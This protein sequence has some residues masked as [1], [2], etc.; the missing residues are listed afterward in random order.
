MARSGVCLPREH[1]PW[2]GRG[3]PHCCSRGDDSP[4][5]SSPNVM[6]RW[7]EPGKCFLHSTFFCPLI[8]LQAFSFTFWAPFYLASSSRAAFVQLTKE[9]RASDGKRGLSAA[10]S[11]DACSV[12]SPT[13]GA[14]GSMWQASSHRRRLPPH[15]SSSS[16]SQ[17]QPGG[18][19]WQAA[20]VL[21]RGWGELE[22]KKKKKTA[23][24][25]MT[26]VVREGR[27]FFFFVDTLTSLDFNSSYTG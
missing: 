2:R 26:L 21:I 25:T 16:M 20:G 19:T 14:V 12:S 4:A 18:P 8:S 15:G 17:G 5:A 1:G 7:E 3:A 11:A 13:R 9:A 22:E 23:H 6:W 27:K 10:F 24:L